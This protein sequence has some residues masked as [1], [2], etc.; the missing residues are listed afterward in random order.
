MVLVGSSDGKMGA[1]VGDSSSGSEGTSSAL[2]SLLCSIFI[3]HSATTSS[4]CPWCLMH[5]N[6][7]ASRLN[8]N[9][10]LLLGDDRAAIRL[11]SMQASMRSS[12]QMTAVTAFADGVADTIEM[13]VIGVDVE[14]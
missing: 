9:T 2:V 12:L 1:G 7:G 13:T 6:I 11:R 5:N 3:I 4:A 10:S 8:R 14:G